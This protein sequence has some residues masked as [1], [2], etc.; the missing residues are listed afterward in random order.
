MAVSAHVSP[1]TYNPW[2]APLP[3][4]MPNAAG[5]PFAA[6]DTTQGLVLEERPV[7]AARVSKS[8]LAFWTFAVLLAGAVICHRNGMLRQWFGATPHS[9]YARLEAQLLGKPSIETVAGVRA[10]LAEIDFGAA[11]KTTSNHQ[12]PQR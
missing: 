2:A 4:G 11:S 5:S 3:S 7:T 6:T 1:G 12:R 10:Y 9:S 8:E